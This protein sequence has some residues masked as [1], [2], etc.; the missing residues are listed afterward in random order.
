MSE[1]KKAELVDAIAQQVNGVSKKDIEAVL[2]ALGETVAE[3][4]GRGTTVPLPGLGKFSRSERAAR[5][6]RN[7]STGEVIQVPAS[8]APSFKAAKPFKDRVNR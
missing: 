2:G 1:M 7:P 4:V 3:N 5:R 8:R 6:G